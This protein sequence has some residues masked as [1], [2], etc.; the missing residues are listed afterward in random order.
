MFDFIDLFSPAVVYIISDVDSF[1][2]T[3]IAFFFYTKKKSLLALVLLNVP[4]L[5][6]AV[7]YMPV[8]VTPYFIRQLL[9]L[10]VLDVALKELV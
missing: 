3:F 1:V 8:L 6:T 5:M 4:F 9:N 2:N 7:L 10:V